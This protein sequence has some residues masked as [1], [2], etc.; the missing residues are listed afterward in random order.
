MEALIRKRRGHL[1]NLMPGGAD[2]G[3]GERQ[4]Y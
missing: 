3:E 4:I 2:D 1:A